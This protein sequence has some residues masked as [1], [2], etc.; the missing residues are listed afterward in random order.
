MLARSWPIHYGR[1]LTNAGRLSARSRHMVVHASTVAAEKTCTIPSTPTLAHPSYDIVRDEMIDEYGVRATMY[2][3]KKSGAEVMSIEAP[4]ENKVFGITFRTPPKDSTGVP[5]ILEHS[6]L[7]GSRKYKSKEPFVE[8]LKGSLQTFLN[9]FTYPDRTCYPVAS[10]NTKDFYNLVNVY[11]DAVL[12]PRAVHDELVLRQEGWH[13][14]LEDPSA[15][16]TLKGVVY[17]E[18]KGVYS[19]PDSLLGRQSQ[20]VLFPD[21]TYGVDSGGDPPVIPD[22]TFDGFKGFHGEFYHP[23]NSRIFFYGDDAP[24]KRLELLDE[25]LKDF[26]AIVPD[27]E[28]AIQRKLKLNTATTTRTVERFPVSESE[29]GKEHMVQINW[30]LNDEPFTSKEGLTLAVLNHLL[31]GTS[32]ACLQKALTDSGLGSA[33]IGGGLSDELSQ[34]TFSIGLKGVAPEDASKVEELVFDILKQIVED[35]FDQSALDAS[36][37]SLE[38]RLREFNTG[39]F[40]K[41]LS[42]MLGAM[43]GW[44]YDRDPLEPLRFED[45]L[46]ELKSDLAENK[47]VFTDMMTSLLLENEHRVTVEMVPDTELEARQEEEEASRLAD[48]KSQMTDQ[49]INDVIAETAR[50]REAQ[51]THDSPEDLATIPALS[52]SDLP[53]KGIELHNEVSIEQGVTVLRHDVPSNGI[54]YAD[55]GLDLSRLPEVDLP[56]MGLFA[57]CLTETGTDKE[58]S[59]SLSRRI[60]SKTGGLGVSVLR[61]VKIPADNVVVAGDDLVQRLFVRGKAVASSSEDLF[62]IVTDILTGAQL[63]NQKRVVEMLKESKARQESSLV[64]AGHSYAAMRLASSGSKLGKINEHT[65]G[66]EYLKFI[67]EL[68][69][70]AENDWPIVQARL[71]AIRSTLLHKPSML[72]NLSGDAATLKTI[73]PSLQSFLEGM[74][75]SETSLLTT[76]LPDFSQSGNEGYVV[77]TQVNYVGKGGRIFDIGE[78]ISGS[79]SVVARS[80]RTGYLWDTVRVMGGAYGGMCSFSALRGTFTFLSYRDPNLLG[81]IKNYDGAGEFLQTSKLTDEALSQAIIGAV[82]DMDSPL[83][84]DAKGWEAMRRYLV[85]ETSE[86]RQDWREEILGTTRSDFVEFGER[87]DGLKGRSVVVGSKKALEEANSASDDKYD[88]IEL[89]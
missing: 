41:G 16:L 38:F 64:S 49:E 40:P 22:L 66:V 24:E 15:P 74:P 45:A 32:A 62:D 70:T 86:Q 59:V 50:L 71:E 33:V 61:E 52:L 30:L 78:K 48:I 10:C 77:P 4:D 1:T 21:N 17:N 2:K 56:Y 39:S 57:R 89:L 29:T 82:G 46:A 65:A 27:S 72:I 26:D 18:M 43:S 58:D 87:L 51:A 25:Y 79:S 60:G 13:Y 19:S 63:N 47:P 11:L 75:T 8:L 54:L 23:S 5:H 53:T 88:L 81:T 20:Q 34:A 6:V 69:V 9:A 14:E 85:E 42:M 67:R 76:S 37:N 44:I 28:I 35:G 3:H 7:C 55:V 73:E 68:L 36:M 80:L 84:P 83:A 12:H 31:L